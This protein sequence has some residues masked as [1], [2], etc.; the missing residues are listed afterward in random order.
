MTREGLELAVILLVLIVI[1]AFFHALNTTVHAV[2]DDLPGI[3]LKFELMLEW[4][5]RRLDE[6][7]IVAHLVDEDLQALNIRAEFLDVVAMIA[8]LCIDSDGRF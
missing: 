5:L 1:A 3:G 2:D 8:A 7:E 6:R 4:S